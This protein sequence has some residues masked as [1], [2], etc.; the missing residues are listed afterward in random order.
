M[1]ALSLSS[2]HKLGAFPGWYRILIRSV[3]YKAHKS[4]ISECKEF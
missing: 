4:E 3:K 2:K 1:F